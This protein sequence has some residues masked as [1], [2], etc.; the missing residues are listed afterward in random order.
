MKANDKAALVATHTELADE[1][2]RLG[3]YTQE[4]AIQS[5]TVGLLGALLAAVPVDPEP[6]PEAPQA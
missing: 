5:K 6:A 4:Y 1:V 3:P 2:S